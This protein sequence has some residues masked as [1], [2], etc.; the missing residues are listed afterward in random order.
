MET[1]ASVIY[2]KS[3]L[4]K[5]IYPSI[6]CSVCFTFIL[7]AFYLISYIEKNLFEKIISKNV[8]NV[9]G[10]SNLISEISVQL[11]NSS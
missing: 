8:K 6:I 10:K 4:L 5:S 11:S 9:F 7:E 3:Y 2:V 1:C